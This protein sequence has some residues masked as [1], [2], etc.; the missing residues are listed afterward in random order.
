VR[1]KAWKKGDPEPEAWTI[2]VPHKTAHQN[3]SPGLF[4][5]SPQEQR[6]WIDNIS[7]T[8]NN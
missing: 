2:E 6:A 4:G 5:F 3:G 1:G 7:V 8:S